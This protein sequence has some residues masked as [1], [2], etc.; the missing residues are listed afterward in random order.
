[1]SP[2]LPTTTTTTLPHERNPDR[3][4]V[5]LIVTQHCPQSCGNGSSR[6]R[7]RPS[8]KGATDPVRTPRPLPPFEQPAHA[9]HFFFAFFLFQGLYG[10]LDSDGFFQTTVT[11]VGPTAKQSKVLH[12]YVRPRPFPLPIVD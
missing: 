12:P 2:S 3:P 5:Y 1:M 10:R 11:N 6:T 4:R 7:T 9:P 8:P